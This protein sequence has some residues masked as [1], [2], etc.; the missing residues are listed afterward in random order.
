MSKIKRNLNLTIELKSP[1]SDVQSKTISTHPSTAA[2]LNRSADKR[3][4]NVTKDL[5][6]TTQINIFTIDQNT[7]QKK[8]FPSSNHSVI[9]TPVEIDMDSGLF[10]TSHTPKPERQKST[11]RGSTISDD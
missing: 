3:T 6:Y 10:I 5:N 7:P 2:T 1:A 11:D 4:A 8:M 9:S